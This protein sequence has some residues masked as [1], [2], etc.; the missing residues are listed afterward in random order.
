MI[1]SN[2]SAKKSGMQKETRYIKDKVK[3]EVSREDR[4]VEY[5]LLNFIAY[6]LVVF[7]EAQKR[8]KVK[9]HSE[10]I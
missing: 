4:R 2:N 9:I 7:T 1:H 5:L 10:D 6:Q 8:F 3:S